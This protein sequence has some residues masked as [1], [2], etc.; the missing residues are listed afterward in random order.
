MK[1]FST[2]L[3]CLFST[4]SFAQNII[5]EFKNPAKISLCDT[6][7]FSV[8]AK[9][10]DAKT[11]TNSEVYIELPAGFSYLKNS[12]TNGTEKTLISN[13]IFDFNFD[14]ITGNSSKTLTFKAFADCSAL[15]ELNKGVL[16]TN[17]VIVRY[18]ANE[19]A[20]ETDPYLVESPLPIIVS[21][22]DPYI[23]GGKG[24]IL[25]RTIVIE[26]T[27]L[28]DLRSFTFQDNHDGGMTV[29]SSS[30][31]TILSN[32]KQ[33][34]LSFGTADFKTIGDG[35]ALFETGE[36]IIIKEK[37]L[38]TDCGDQVP[39]SV[40][41][42]Q[43]VWGCS[44]QT[45]NTERFTA[46]VDILR[47]D[48]VPNLELESFYSVA[49]D[50]CAQTPDVQGLKIKNTGKDTA[51]NVQI[52]VKEVSS[53]NY[54]E[55][56]SYTLKNGNTTTKLTPTSFIASM[57]K[58]CQP[59]IPTDS[60]DVLAL[61]NLSPGQEVVLKWNYLTC[62]PDCDD[63]KPVWYAKATYQKTCPKLE[64]VSSDITV[65]QES[66]DPY[67]FSAYAKYSV[68]KDNEILNAQMVFGMDLFKDST[69]VASFKL[70]LP[71]GLK[72]IS[73]PLIVAGKTPQTFDI[74][75]VGKNQIISAS[76][77]LPLP[78]SAVGDY[79]LRFNCDV[80]C[81]KGAEN[82]VV[83]ISD[84]TDFL[85]LQADYYTDKALGKMTSNIKI[86][87]GAG[88]GINRC[89]EPLFHFD[90]TKNSTKFDTLKG[91]SSSE[92][93]FERCNFGLP[94]NDDN[95]VADG[96]G[97]LDLSKIRRD[98][99]VAG[100]TAAFILKSKLIAQNGVDTFQF[101][102]VNILFE[103][104]LSDMDQK[105]YGSIGF[106]SA[107]FNL[108]HFVPLNTNLRVFDKK[109]SKY[110][111]CTLP[112][113]INF[114]D[115]IDLKY[116]N[117]VPNI[118]K[119][120]IMQVW[121][122]YE[123][124]SKSLLGLPPN[125]I[126]SDGDSILVAG[127]YFIKLAP[128]DFGNR[129]PLALSMRFNAGVS[130]YNDI[131]DKKTN[132]FCA[133]NTVRFHASGLGIFQTFPKYPLLDCQPT[134]N[135][136]L[137]FTFGVIKQ[138][139]NFFP[140]EFRT[141]AKMPTMQISYSSPID[142]LSAKAKTWKTQGG[143]THFTNENIP[144]SKI[145]TNTYSLDL[146]SLQMPPQDEGFTVELENTFQSN[147]L[148]AVSEEIRSRYYINFNNTAIGK[149]T[150]C[151]G[152]DAKIKAFSLDYNKLTVKSLYNEYNSF[153]NTAL[154][155]LEYTNPSKYNTPNPYLYFTN[156]IGLQDI[157]VFNKATGNEILPQ[158]GL[159]Y[160]PDVAPN[161]TYNIL[162]SAINNTCDE[163]KIDVNYGWNCTKINAIA[164]KSCLEKKY[165]L[166]VSPTPG[167]IELRIE[168]PMDTTK[169][170]EPMGYFN[171]DVLSV[172][173][174]SVFNPTVKL[175]L[176]QG[177]SV[178]PGSCQVAYPANSNNFVNV[179]DPKTLAS[180]GLG[181]NLADLVAKIQQNGL[182]G[183]GQKPNNTVRLRFKMLTKCGFSAGKNFS[184][185]IE[186]FEIC[187]KK[188]NELTRASKPIFLQGV[189]PLYTTKVYFKPLYAG[190][191]KCDQTAKFSIRAV[192]NG[193]TG[194]KDS[195]YVYLPLHVQYL[196]FDVVNN[197][198]PTLPPVE[199]V[200]GNQ[201]VIKW[202]I[203]QGV[204]PGAYI[205]IVIYTK[206]WGKNACKN[207]EILVKTIQRQETTCV[208]NSELCSVSNVTGESNSLTIAV[209]HP[210]YEITNAVVSHKDL[211]LNYSINVKNLLSA[212]SI[213]G[214]ILDL[215]ADI[216]NNQIFDKGIDQ[217]LGNTFIDQSFPNGKT[218]LLVGKIPA[219]PLGDYICNL[220][221]VLDKDQ[222]CGC[223]NVSIPIK[224]I[225]VEQKA[226]SVCSNTSTPIGLNTKTGFTYAWSPAQNLSCTNCAKPNFLFTNN[227]N[228]NANFPFTLLV[229]NDD[230]TA[231][232]VQNVNV[233]PNPKITTLA[234]AICKGGS[235]T[236]TTTKGIAYKWSGSGI[237]AANENK[238]SQT[239]SPAQ[240]SWY[241][242][243]ITDVNFCKG[244]DS[245]L[246]KVGGGSG[247]KEDTICNG[248]KV[249][250]NNTTYT[251]SGV[252]D[253]KY[254]IGLNC[255]SLL[256][257][258][259]TVL[260]TPQIKINTV[261]VV[262]GQEVTLQAPT[263]F[264]SY[265]W[266]PSIGLSCTDCPD[267]KVTPIE[268]ITY[269]VL[270]K[271]SS[272]C[273]GKAAVDVQILP[274]C[275][276]DNIRPVLVFTPEGDIE[277]NKVFRFVN[278]KELLPKFGITISVLI[279]NRW[280]EIVKEE[281][282]GD[283]QW[284]GIWNDK[285]ASTDVYIL[286]YEIKC[287]TTSLKNETTELT[288]LR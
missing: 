129:E 191:L 6:V 117:I 145:F 35:D 173:F 111:N 73:G 121:N 106:T 104:R 235:V 158:N 113:S 18:G 41:K 217:F 269:T 167:E 107:Y 159:Y 185:K 137:V 34:H 258:K 219:L 214:M 7:S 204:G 179:A 200:I 67:I 232:I 282:S 108:S 86:F 246:L 157:K 133:G 278:G 270:A 78:D 196:S 189:T 236:L 1:N 287:G 193:Y 141:F 244:I 27:R 174:G 95:R 182:A 52:K 48:Y 230:C 259:L 149:D 110:Y 40:S 21:M 124:N 251:K 36:Q 61:P 148:E 181:W 130:L 98:H 81:H 186:G 252:Y 166:Y 4:F 79:Q 146:S 28:G 118:S 115:G 247:T 77:K 90:C 17:L 75:Q 245:V 150:I 207:D 183:I 13:R 55:R 126:F 192:P 248:E 155:E 197:N 19:A 136:S 56:N 119:D 271:T 220:L 125:Y 71:C 190:L 92:V 237:T 96:N 242:V 22:T 260:D 70:T 50:Y 215:Y 184:A 288:L 143:Q 32:S 53:A 273:Q 227:S 285:P 58:L 272:Q 11:A 267:P 45:C 202:K 168:N 151:Y 275:A 29:T 23:K 199:E 144:I 211:N 42:F 203:P 265:L 147:C 5:V 54:L 127:K 222:N 154:W 97:S 233:F 198:S 87:D 12:V 116:L 99:F 74:Q 9:N 91:Y 187:G 213:K 170:C 93:A 49:R 264:V 234:P 152:C 8:I 30:G 178:Q 37:I 231:N 216:N 163:A 161:T 156:A 188:T 169:M 64:I 114:Q 208:S 240:T 31:K 276:I 88:C 175:T 162:I 279:F 238:E 59:S 63:I 26:N 66:S 60:V 109:N 128:R 263:G 153:D 139:T 239:V 101:A 243:T 69:G 51:Y 250:L 223:Q 24:D 261:K 65:N 218:Q 72:W 16:F 180:G 10:T 253:I 135:N 266:T 57:P 229:K 256:T 102:K 241:K 123:L 281:T 39:K 210:S 68:L 134:T 80:D 62:A 171:I 280:G 206:G 176:P 38:V 274:N 138:F 249:I 194:S 100:D 201:R 105:K 257:F 226:L 277:V 94:D 212:D 83:P 132:Q 140:Y 20:I 172:R 43:I 286:K 85:P 46:V 255:D 122:T 3:F 131:N 82:Y 103:W 120:T 254:K 14:N 47:T 283:P 209:A 142:F 225:L 195:I 160:L 221:L 268:N 44:T 25:E 112:Q 164:E 84:C 262:L 284:D 205:G 165:T 33:L 2:L 15:A 89:D 76:Y 177:L 228:T 224:N